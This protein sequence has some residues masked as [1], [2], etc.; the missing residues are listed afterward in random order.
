ANLC[1]AVGLHGDGVSNV[2]VPRA[3]CPCG[4]ALIGVERAYGVLESALSRESSADPEEPPFMRR[5][6][7]SVYAV[8]EGSDAWVARAGPLEDLPRPVVELA[9]LRVITQAQMAVCELVH[10]LQHVIVIGP[11]LLGRPPLVELEGFSRQVEFADFRQRGTHHVSLRVWR[12][13]P[14]DESG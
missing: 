7:A 12:C 14:G 10:S 11:V 1:V 3:V 9:G 5:W 2:L 6:T 4:P 13:P 8:R